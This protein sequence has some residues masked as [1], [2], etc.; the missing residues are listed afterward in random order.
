MSRILITG[1]NGFIGQALISSL[2]KKNHHHVISLVRTGR[3]NKQVQ[4]EEKN[5]ED[6]DNLSKLTS[7]KLAAKHKL[8]TAD[9]LDK[10]VE[11]GFLILNENGKHLLTEQG[12]AMGGEFRT[13]QY[14]GYFLWSESTDL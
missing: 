5:D 4:V 12:K 8:K 3:T 6:A 13:S 14:G 2:L 11:K 7:S 9:L 1:G 10:F